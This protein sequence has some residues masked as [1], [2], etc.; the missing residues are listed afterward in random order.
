MSNNNED[1]NILLETEN[2]DQQVKEVDVIIDDSKENICFKCGFKM[3]S[4]QSCH[5]KCEN[6]GAEKD[7]SDTP[8]W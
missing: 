8:A 3:T 7:C 4:I 1:E 5:L 2:I 6:C